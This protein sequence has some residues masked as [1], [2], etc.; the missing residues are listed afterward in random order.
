MGNTEP[1]EQILAKLALGD[2]VFQTDCGG[3]ESH[4]HRGRT[5]A[6]H[7]IEFFFSRERRS[8]TWRA[9]TCPDLIE[10]EVLLR[11]ERRACYT[12]PVKAPFMPKAR[13]AISSALQFTVTKGGARAGVDGA[14]EAAGP[15][16]PG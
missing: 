5:I 16:L 12:A 1:V 13:S 15:A 9:G 8:F 11:G 14:G 4:V 6:P 3:D 10:E 7:R 2:G